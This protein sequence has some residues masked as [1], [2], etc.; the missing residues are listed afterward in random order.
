MT[1]WVNEKATRRIKLEFDKNGNPKF[2]STQSPESFK[3]CALCVKPPHTVIPIIF[4]P[5]I[6]GTNLKLRG[7]RGNAWS[8]PNGVFSG[9]GAAGKGAM[10]SPGTRQGLFDPKETEVNWDGPCEAPSDVFWLTSEEA[11]KRGWGALH[12]ESYHGILS[13]LEISL[14]DQYSKPGLPKERG[15]FLLPEIGLL[16]HLAGGHSKAERVKGE[17]DYSFLAEETVTA[18]NKVP[19]SLSQEDV[20]KLDDYYY[21]VWAHGYNWLQ[22]NEESAQSLIVKIDE[23]IAYY[24]KSDYFHCD[25]KVILISH[26]MGGLV[27]RRAAQLAEDKVLGI[28]H[29]VQPVAGAPVVYR[30]FRAGTEVGGFFDIVGAATASIIGWNAADV[31]PTLACSPGPLELLPTKHYPS[32]WLRVVKGSGARE[33][34]LIHLPKADPYEEIYS[35]TTDECWWGMLDPDLIDPANTIKTVAPPRQVYE[36]SLSKAE[37]FHDTVGLYAHPQT[38]GYYGADEKKYRAFGQ[39]SWETESLPDDDALPLLL[40]K[41]SG[42]S[43]TGKSTVSLYQ[44]EGSPKVKLKLR[45]ERNQAGDGTV[46]LDSGAVLAKLQPTPQAV[47]EMRGFDHQKSYGDKFT[48]RATIYGIARLIQLAEPAKP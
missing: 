14:N 11:K 1:A 16:S 43:L 46:P 33:E 22:S 30:R 21:P 3:Q 8:P 13:Q 5:G 6:M 9:I 25:G 40:N 42:R 45:N 7:G 19:K 15:N 20:L 38:Y 10:Q 37:L 39:V 18:W 36:T 48:I 41:D 35:K 34:V 31:T 44:Q 24:Q 23:I 4:V 29:G 28:V 47:F 17:P 12:A 27:T 2:N 32:G 26:S